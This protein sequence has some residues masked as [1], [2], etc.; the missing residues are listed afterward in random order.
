MYGA[1]EIMSACQIHYMSAYG[2]VVRHAVH[3][4][5]TTLTDPF[6]W[7]AG[8]NY[9]GNSSLVHAQ[10]IIATLAVQ[11]SASLLPKEY[12]VFTGSVA[13][14]SY[15]AL[16]PSQPSAMTSGLPCAFPSPLAFAKAK[17]PVRFVM[18]ALAPLSSW[19]NAQEI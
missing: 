18:T 9:L 17:S 13:N 1:S 19:P 7:Y 11:A 16:Q 6:S 15:S 14:Y 2:R 10:S 3:V 5:I 4:T 8:L 12:F